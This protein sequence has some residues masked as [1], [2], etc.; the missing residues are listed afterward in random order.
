MFAY[1]LPPGAPFPPPDPPWPLFDPNAGPDA[2]LALP[3][4]AGPLIVPA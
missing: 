2:P 1:M 3:D 4:D